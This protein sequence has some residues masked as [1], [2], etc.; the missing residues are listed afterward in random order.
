VGKHRIAGAIAAV[1]LACGGGGAA[2]AQTFDWN[3]K[4]NR[5]ILAG[6]L[7]NWAD[8]CSGVFHLNRVPKKPN[9]AL[10]PKINSHLLL[11]STP[12]MEVERWGGWLPYMRT[13]SAVAKPAMDR[14]A[15]ALL[16]ARAD[17]SSMAAAEK[18]YT[19]TLRGHFQTVFGKCQEGAH[20]PFIAEN[21]YSGEGDFDKVMQQVT[22]DFASSVQSLDEPEPKR[23]VTK[24]RR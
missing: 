12:M 24:K 15:D 4:P 9:E 17:P 20:E 21:F 23:V 13:D 1:S 11:S 8:F 18:L 6:A 14:A 16:A 22:I 2:Q 7:N 19:D 10:E 3:R 5:I